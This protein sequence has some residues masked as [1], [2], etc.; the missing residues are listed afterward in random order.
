MFYFENIKFYAIIYKNIYGV[1]M[2][3]LGIAMLIVGCVLVAGLAV[4][5][6]FYFKFLYKNTRDQTPASFSVKMPV[7]YI[8]LAFCGFVVTIFMIIAFSTFWEANANVAMYILFAVLALI[9][10]L[11][12]FMLMYLRIVVKGEIITVYNLKGKHKYKLENI[13]YKKEINGYFGYACYQNDKK[14]FK[15]N[16]YCFGYEYMV[17]YL[18]DV[19][20]YE[21]KPKREFHAFKRD[22]ENEENR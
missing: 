10:L 17:K 9:C 4:L 19:P 14:I 8:I 13:Q 3:N 18:E 2:S 16:A 22:N 21:Y 5:L 12:I 20:L 15:V 6:G 11:I 7:W 1:N